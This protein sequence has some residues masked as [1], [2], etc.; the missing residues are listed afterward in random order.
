ML[1][2]FIDNLIHTYGYL[3]VLL[4]VGLESVGIPLPGETVLITA[5]LYAGTTHH[6]N[7]VVVAAAAS[8]AA[9]VGDNI[10]YLLGRTVGER[11]LTRFGQRLHLGPTRLAVGRYLFARHGAKVMFFGRFVTVLRTCAALLAG[12]NRMPWRKFA[13]A[14]TAGAVLWACFYSVGAYYL[15]ARSAAFGTASTI[16]GLALSSVVT[17]VVI[18]L[19]RRRFRALEERLSVSAEQPELHPELLATP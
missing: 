1:T 18:V 13:A 9:I 7:I 19:G 16:V 3:A 17:V 12:L 10:G 5:A 6:L 8:G 2:S 4:L 15:G 14:N 11:L